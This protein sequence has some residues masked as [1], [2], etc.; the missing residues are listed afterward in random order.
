MSEIGCNWDRSAAPQ[1][2]QARV[3]VDAGEG[4][5]QQELNPHRQL[6]KSCSN[7]FIPCPNGVPG[8]AAL[9][10]QEA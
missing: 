3:N 1:K 6:V 8:K 2:G 4:T 10:E 7:T 9:Y 5:G